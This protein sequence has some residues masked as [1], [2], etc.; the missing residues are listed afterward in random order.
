MKFEIV[1]SNRPLLFESNAHNC[2]LAHHYRYKVE[3]KIF[4]R[5][6]LHLPIKASSRQYN[7]FG[8]LSIRKR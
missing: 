3:E 8:L 6:F 1:E 7:T 2:I 5:M 4:T